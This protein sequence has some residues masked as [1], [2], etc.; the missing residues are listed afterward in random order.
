[1]NYSKTSKTPFLS[2]FKL[3][4]AQSTPLENNTMYRKLVHCLLYFTHTRPDIYYVVSVDSKYMDQPHDIHWRATKRILDFVQG[5]KTH[6]IHNVAQ[7]SLD[8]VTFY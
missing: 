4:E 7:S 5:T 3:E 2:G 8:L 1:M 6:V